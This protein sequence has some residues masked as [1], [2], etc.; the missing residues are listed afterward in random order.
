MVSIKSLITYFVGFES[1]GMIALGRHVAGG[2]R[3]AGR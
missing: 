2:G 3:L 1:R